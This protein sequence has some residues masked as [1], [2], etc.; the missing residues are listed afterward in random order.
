M[1]RS[2]P[3]KKAPA[4][5]S[6]KKQKVGKA[7]RPAE[8]ATNVSFKTRSVVIPTQLEQPEEPTTHRKLPLQVS[9]S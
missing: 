1:K 7:K 9:L 3:S 5:F 6:K 8:N 2:R 4:D